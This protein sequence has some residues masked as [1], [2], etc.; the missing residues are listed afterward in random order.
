MSGRSDDN[1]SLAYRGDDC[2]CGSGNAFARCHGA[3]EPDAPEGRGAPSAAAACAHTAVSSLSADRSAGIERRVE[4]DPLTGTRFEHGGAVFELGSILMTNADGVVYEA[5]EVQTGRSDRVLKVYR[6]RLSEEQLEQNRAAYRECTR[7]LGERFLDAEF[8]RIGEQAVMLQ[9]RASD[10]VPS[11]GR[12]LQGE[13]AQSSHKDP[14]D[15][16]AG[17]WNDRFNEI[18]E[19]SNARDFARV[20]QK[21]DEALKEFTVDPYFLRS[22]GVALLAMDES[23]A[24]NEA[25]HLCFETHPDDAEHYAAVIHACTALGK[26]TW[27]RKWGQEGARR[28]RDRAQV[29]KAWFDAEEKAADVPRLRMCLAQLRLLEEPESSLEALRM[30]LSEVADRLARCEREQEGAW[31]LLHQR[32]LE[33]AEQMA[34]RLTQ[35]HP[36]HVP[37]LFLSGVLAMERDQ[38]AEAIRWLRRAFINQPLGDPD[39][40]FLM[41]HAYLKLGRV[42]H[43]SVMHSVWQQDY[44]EAA[45][46]LERR[47]L[48]GQDG[49]GA[50]A[51]LTF[52]SECER[53][54]VE[55]TAAAAQQGRGILAAYRA[56]SDAERATRARIEEVVHGTERLLTWLGGV[57]H[58]EG[59]G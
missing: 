35:E 27:V 48:R 52:A 49:A 24:A 14:V 21:C 8:F 10:T 39:V 40:P 4:P 30:R 16:I 18:I 36:H 23:A 20:V 34:R 42:H 3:D 43:A 47:G 57:S 58:D 22:K 53:R 17:L 32:R 44:N 19:L 37:A 33:E 29:Y 9:R 56:V 5:R 15:E 31:R 46:S 55:D 28:A 7:V 54:L 13:R 2:P 45:A 38:W 25:L 41:G 6:A 1:P 11:T 51:G 26:F 59:A 12:A 50:M